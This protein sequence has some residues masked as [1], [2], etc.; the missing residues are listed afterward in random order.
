VALTHSLALLFK[1][2]ILLASADART[3][4]IAIS[5]I[6]AIVT[7]SAI[8]L[9]WLVTNACFWVACA[10]IMALA[11]SGAL[12]SVAQVHGASTDPSNALVIAG[13]G[14]AIVTI[15]SILLGRLGA[16][17]IFHVACANVIARTGSFAFHAKAQIPSASADATVALIIKGE[18]PTIVTISS[19]LLGRLGADTILR[20]A[21][22]NVVAW[23][24]CHTLYS[25]TQ[26]HGACALALPITL[27]IAGAGVAIIACTAC[28]LEGCGALALPR[29]STNIVTLTPGLA[30]VPIAPVLCASTNSCLFITLVIVGCRVVVITGSSSLFHWIC[31]GTLDTH[32][33][34]VALTG[35]LTRHIVARVKARCLR[36]AGSNN[37]LS[38][39]VHTG[40]IMQVMLRA[41]V[42]VVSNARESAAFLQ[43]TLFGFSIQ[44]ALCFD[45]KGV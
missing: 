7:L 22:A 31:A 6:Q 1:A 15:S 13:A 16:N 39:G 25:S 35:R 5:E 20:V 43:M 12:H 36:N 33:N 24:L 37:N 9:G 28:W 8:L 4:L 42:K 21:N 2:R 29:A 41:A 19:I 23:T 38:E 3:A 26:V 14:V 27:V 44:S 40:L 17:T 32:T 11:R 34:I 18:I 45:F 30:R 10:N